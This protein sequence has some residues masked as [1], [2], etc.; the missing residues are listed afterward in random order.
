[1]KIKIVSDIHLEISDYKIDNDV[2]ADVLILAGD[3]LVGEKLNMGTSLRDIHSASIFHNFLSECN[4]LFNHVIYVLGNHEYYHG[5]INTTLSTIKAQCMKYPNIHVLE[6]ESLT[7]DDVT[8]LGTTLWTNMDNENP[9]SIHS[10]KNGMSDFQI[11]RN[12]Y[13]PLSPEDTI[14]LFNESIDFLSTEMLKYTDNKV[15]VITHHT[16]SFQSLHPNYAGN[17]LNGAFLNNLDDFILNNSIRLW[18]HGHVH[19]SFDY[20][21]GNTQVVCNPRGYHSYWGDETT[22]FNKDKVVIL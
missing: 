1:M 9:L 19:T 7:I 3:I 11:I 8:F 4:Q 15:V 14:K 10:A 13:R 6:K 5:D 16:P 12:G 22:N 18:C 2:Q 17:S 20:I 21:L